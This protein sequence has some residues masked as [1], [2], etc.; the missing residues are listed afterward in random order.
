MRNGLI[1]GW[2]LGGAHLKAALV[3]QDAEARTVL[4]LPCPLWQGMDNLSSAL[5]EAA[6]QVGAAGRHAVTMTGELVDLFDSRSAGVEALI[7]GFTAAFPRAEVLVYGGRAGFLVPDDARR[8]PTDVASANW[9]AS[10]RF[11]AKALPQG[12][13]IDVGSTTTDLVPFRGGRDA[14]VGLVDEERLIS[15]ELV[16]TGVTRTPVMAVAESVPFDGRR[17][18]LMAELF[19]TM[20]DVHRLTGELPAD[21]D[22][23]PTADGRDKSVA[24]SALRLSR[25]LGRDAG[26]ASAAAW[27][28][29]AHYL[30][31]R[32]RQVIQD[33][34]MRVLSRGLIAEEAPLVGAGI[35]RFLVRTLAAGLGRPYT[36]FGDLVSGSAE[37]KEWAAR[38]APA[39]A[40]AI[41][42]AKV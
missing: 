36:D 40:V 37:A 30:A 9:L 41:L 31:E 33:A 3:D 8:R 32:Q 24:A 29:V 34:A 20:A 42:A 21:A 28:R 15:E 25:M 19:A 5:T 6:T 11:A 18:R 39:A 10:V 35:G 1:A 2:D 38:C 12:L 17:Q 14:A 7:D 27:H 4:Q 23:D 13:F 26:S 16:Y 22:Q